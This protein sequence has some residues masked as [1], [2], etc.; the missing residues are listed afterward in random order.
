MS[1]LSIVI[2]VYNSYCSLDELIESL[3]LRYPEC[4]IV[5]V[6]DNSH[7]DSFSKLKELYERYNSLKIIRLD[8]NY[9]QQQAIKCGLK[10]T[11]HEYIVTMDDDLQ[12]PVSEISKL[13]TEV[14]KGFD[15]CYGVSLHKPQK[16]FRKL[17]S[18]L[19]DKLFNL[20][21]KKPN[22]IK[23]SSFRCLNRQ[24]VD[25]INQ[26]KTSFVYLSAITLKLT[27]NITTIEVANNQRKY[28]KS[29]YNY[30]KLFKLFIKLYIYYQDKTWLKVFRVTKKQYSIAEKY[31]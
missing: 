27:K 29:Q 18:K 16:C 22:D 8:K 31:I 26:D 11:S 15:V 4:E 6:D 20:I 14:K 7:D 21:T 17:G 1:N 19:T 10:F 23:V 25:Q 12:H 30:W 28:G 3:K 24:I 9:G 13:V 2:P 5:L